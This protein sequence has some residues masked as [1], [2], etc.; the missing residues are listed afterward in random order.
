MKHGRILTHGQI[1]K[2]H[3]RISKIFGQLHYLDIA[4]SVPQQL[5]VAASKLAEIT[6]VFAIGTEVEKPIEEDLITKVFASNQPG[7]PL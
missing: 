2:M 5:L 4:F 1:N 7:A 3:P 6:I